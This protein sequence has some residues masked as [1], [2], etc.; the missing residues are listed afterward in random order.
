MN[1]K[2]LIVAWA[3]KGAEL[4]KALI[5][6]LL[7]G[8]VLSGCADVKTNEENLADK[9]R[10]NQWHIN[11]SQENIILLTVKHNIDKETLKKAIF[12]YERMVTG[13]SFVG[14]FEEL[15]KGNTSVKKNEKIEIISVSEAIDKV[16]NK[17]EIS[18]EKLVTILIEL[19]MMES[20]SYE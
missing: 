16:S 19:K 6:F 12:D 17:Y 15:G 2:Q 1:K 9:K 14:A 10:F 13:Y 5:L 18:Q 20:G 8:I 11:L 3:K 4:R 7:L